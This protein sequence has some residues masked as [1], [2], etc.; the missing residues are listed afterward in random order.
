MYFLILELI[1][2]QGFS[3]LIKYGRAATVGERLIIPENY[4]EKPIIKRHE[5][6]FPVPNNTSLRFPVCIVAFYSQ[7]K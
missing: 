5:D 6:R 2:I 3:K 1:L 7:L 4:N